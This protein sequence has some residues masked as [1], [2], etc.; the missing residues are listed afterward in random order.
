MFTQTSP[1]PLGFHLRLCA[2]IRTRNHDRLH[3]HSRLLLDRIRHL[4][5]KK[6]SS[7]TNTSNIYPS[8]LTSLPNI[9]SRA[10]PRSTIAIATAHDEQTYRRLLAITPYRRRTRRCE[11]KCRL[12]HLPRRRLRAWED[13]LHLH[14]LL[15]DFPD[16]QQVP[17]EYVLSSSPLNIMG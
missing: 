17:E 5:V 8:I 16:Q 11:L 6:Q 9:L 10:A 2:F 4:L 14:H 7:P 15:E 12:H 3:Q 1:P 13:P